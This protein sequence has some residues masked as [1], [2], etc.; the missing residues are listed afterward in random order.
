M[1]QSKTMKTEPRTKRGTRHA[2]MLRRQGKIPACLLS[3]G[4]KKS[5]EIVLD[6]HAFMTARRHHVHL[7]ELEVGGEVETA[8][9]R[10]LQW[11]AFGE[12]IL[13][14]DFKR[15]RR[16][17]ETEAEV[18]LTFVGHPKTGMLNHLVTRVTVRC[19]PA[20]IPDEIEVPVGHLE[21]GGLI[22]A[23]ELKLPE[24]VM[25]GIP[26]ETPIANS[27][28]VKIELEPVAAPTAEGA[29]PAAGA[30]AAAPGAPA[31]AAGATPAAEAPAKAA[32]KEKKEKG[33]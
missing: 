30:P 4:T 22:V 14:I 17:V 16:D 13:H 23:K 10:E 21:Q 27:V 5:V 1:S 8:L 31:P 33:G 2:R 12:T 24:G 20:L 32:G 26:P 15:V 18:E 9:V 28:L 6:E 7:F 11:D 25:L 3:D 29:V 19:I